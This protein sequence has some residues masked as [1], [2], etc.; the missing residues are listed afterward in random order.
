MTQNDDEIAGLV[1]AAHELTEKVRSIN[2]QTTDAIVELGIVSR[3][4][5][6]MLIAIAGGMLATLVLAVLTA[7]ALLGVNNTSHRLDEVTHRLDVAQTEGRQKALCPLYT[8]FLGAKNPRSRALDPDGP[9]AY[10]AKFK[11]IEQGY[12]G[13]K[14]REFDGDGPKLGPS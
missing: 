13:L 11:I 14:C 5:R 8:L 3:R 4:H 2:T 1:N 12:E 9:A 6:R 10:D 7:L